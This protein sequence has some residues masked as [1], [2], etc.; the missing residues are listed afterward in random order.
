MDTSKKSDLAMV[1]IVERRGE[2][3]IMYESYAAD[4]ELSTILNPDQFLNFCQQHESCL[5][6]IGRIVVLFI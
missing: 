2:V 1:R 4:P 3:C 6:K 5:Q